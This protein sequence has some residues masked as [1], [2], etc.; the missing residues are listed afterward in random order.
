MDNDKIANLLEKVEVLFMYGATSFTRSFASSDTS[1]VPR[2]NAAVCLCRS[3]WPSAYRCLP[4]G[5]AV[6]IQS[7]CRSTVY[8]QWH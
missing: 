4:A 5:S 2:R 3:A 8:V 7:S 6:Q 1:S